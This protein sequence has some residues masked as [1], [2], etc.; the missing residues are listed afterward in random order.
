MNSSIKSAAD[1]LL[2]EDG[3][4]YRRLVRLHSVIAS[5]VWLV[6]F[7]LIFM[8]QYLSPEPSLGNLGTR[9]LL[10]TSQIVLI[11]LGLLLTPFWETGLSYA[12][13]DFIHGKRNM[14][15]DLAEGFRCLK[16]VCGCL[17]FQGIQYGLLYFI[18]NT[19]T[20][21]ILMLFPFSQLFYSDVALL[22]SDVSVPIRGRFVITAAVYGFFFLSIVI[23]IG[24]QLFYRYRLTRYI[25][26]DNEEMGGIRAT[27]ASRGMMR[28]NK[29]KMFK[30]DLSFWWFHIPGLLGMLLP[31]A[32]L[33][34]YYLDIHLSTDWQIAGW[35]AVAVSLV[36]RL[37]VNLIGKPKVAATYALFYDRLVNKESEPIVEDPPQGYRA[38]WQGN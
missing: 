12:A 4:S 10:F 37:A 29:G 21:F 30:L 28:K 15:R 35:I 13:L 18:G 27:A 8:A 19:L 9:A 11:A 14:N 32:A 24:S 34:L 25:I 7:G 26:L 31:V 36:L 22:L 20:S 1:R 33:L 16:P 38:P 23:F 5:G 6:I 3:G 2:R 17:A